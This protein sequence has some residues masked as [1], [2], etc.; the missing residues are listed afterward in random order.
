[1]RLIWHNVPRLVFKLAKYPMFFL[2]NEQMSRSGH[3]L[4]LP[5]PKKH[6]PPPKK[7]N[8]K[9]THKTKNKKKLNF[10]LKVRLSFFWRDFSKSFSI[11]KDDFSVARK[12]SL[13]H[14]FQWGYFFRGQCSVL[15]WVDNFLRRMEGD[16]VLR[17]SFRWN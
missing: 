11:P 8:K 7:K 2:P 12:Q 10:F 3:Q 1:M 6:N 9:T 15:P 4:L 5:W 13:R 14:S 16:N 17:Y